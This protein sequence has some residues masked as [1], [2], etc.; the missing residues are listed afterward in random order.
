MITEKKFLKVEKR[1][2][3]VRDTST[4]AILAVDKE[5]L[6]EH[7]R[8]KEY[9]SNILKNKME[10]LELKEDVKELKTILFLILEKLNLNINK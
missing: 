1:P 3:L 9:H 8:L 5:K 2:D 7:N 4:K 10:V 6:N